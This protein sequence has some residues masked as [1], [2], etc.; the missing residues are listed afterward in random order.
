MLSVYI[1]LWYTERLDNNEYTLCAGPDI[2]LQLNVYDVN[3][4]NNSTSFHSSTHRHSHVHSLTLSLADPY[5]SISHSVHHFPIFHI[6][7][8]WYLQPH[9]RCLGP[10]LP[11]CPALRPSCLPLSALCPSF[12]CALHVTTAIHTGIHYHKHDNIRV[13][14]YLWLYIKTSLKSFIHV[15]T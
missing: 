13:C 10:V 2:T 15:R 1:F 4:T 5:R 8:F 14:V 6:F 11:V 12:R 3:G 9:P 7:C